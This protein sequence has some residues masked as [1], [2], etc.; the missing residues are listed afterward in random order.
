VVLSLDNTKSFEFQ[1]K[2]VDKLETNGSSV[3]VDVG[4]A[5]FFVSTNKRA[6]YINGEMIRL[7]YR[8]P[9]ILVNGDYNTMCGTQSGFF[10]STSTT[11]APRVQGGQDSS[12]NWFFII[13]VAHSENFKM[14]IASPFFEEGLYFRNAINGTWG[15]WKRLS[16][17]DV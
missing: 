7:G 9:A 13:Q 8:E 2:A 14:Q 4:Q 3:N 11:N 16:Y 12:N 5:I 6:C 10:K 17:T 15:K 1:I